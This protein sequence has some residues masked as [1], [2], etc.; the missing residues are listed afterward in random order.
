MK[1]LDTDQRAREYLE[2]YNAQLRSRLI[3]R[4]TTTAIV[5]MVGPVRRKSGGGGRG[6]ITYTD[7]DG[8]YGTA[9][10]E[11]IAEQRDYFAER[12]QWVEWKYHDYDLPVDLPD[13]LRKAGFISEA[14]A[15]IVIGETADHVIADRLPQGVTVRGISA[16]EDLERVRAMQETVW[17][18]QFAWLPG[19]LALELDSPTDPVTVLAAEVEDELVCAAWIRFHKGTEFASLWG[20]STLPAWRG[21]GIYRAIVVRRAQLALAKGYKYLQFACSDDSRSILRR[22]G[23]PWVALTVPYVWKPNGETANL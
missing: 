5:Q 18:T 1:H 3:I 17:G 23:M 19:S 14:A 4:D 15:T 20:G 11:F 16:P 22:M 9:L 10:D 8:L 7:L 2:A 6:V 12:Q 21:K 13:R